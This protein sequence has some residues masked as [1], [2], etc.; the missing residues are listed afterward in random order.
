[1]LGFDYHP[2]RTIFMLQGLKQV[3]TARFRMK[4]PF[5][6]Q[7]TLYL[8][9]RGFLTFLVLSDNGGGPGIDYHWLWH[10]GG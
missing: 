1:M 4:L 7:V 5:E 10:G 2:L 3:L 6:V 8:F 9:M